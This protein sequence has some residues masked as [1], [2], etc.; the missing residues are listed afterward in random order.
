MYIL[1]AGDLNG[2]HSYLDQLQQ[3]AESVS[4]WV[5]GGKIYLDYI[6]INDIVNDMMKVSHRVAKKKTSMS[7]NFIQK[8][9]FS[10]ISYL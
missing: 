6:T 10:S 5:I 2:L 7:L 4:E 9:C 3:G 1:P 8:F